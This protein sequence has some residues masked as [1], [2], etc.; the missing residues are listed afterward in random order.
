[1][2][3]DELLLFGGCMTPS[4]SVVEMM[5]PFVSLVTEMERWYVVATH[6]VRSGAINSAVMIFIFII[7]KWPPMR[8]RQSS[9]K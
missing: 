5:F 1:M 8:V 6:P 3:N 7:C 4:V 2:G 9:V